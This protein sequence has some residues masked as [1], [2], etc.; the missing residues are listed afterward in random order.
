MKIFFDLNINRKPLYQYAAV[1]RLI[2]PDMF[3]QD[4][5][6]RSNAG[7]CPEQLQAD[8]QNND[9]CSSSQNEPS[10]QTQLHK[11]TAAASVSPSLKWPHLWQE[12][13]LLKILCPAGG[14]RGAPFSACSPF[15]SR[16]PRAS[17][18]EPT[19]LETWRCVCLQT[20]VWLKL[21]G[22]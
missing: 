21:A 20:C 14:G 11:P 17:W 12:T 8:V 2:D 1:F 3:L 9:L 15:S 4:R 18:Q 10:S 16:L 6:S 7:C 22:G 5:L 19:S 13:F